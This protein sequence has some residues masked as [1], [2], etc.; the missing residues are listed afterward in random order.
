MA[1]VL[2][3]RTPVR[4][5]FPQ[6]GGLSNIWGRHVNAELGST[7][8]LGRCYST[9]TKAPCTSFTRVRVLLK[10]ER[11][12]KGDVDGVLLAVTNRYTDTIDAAV[13][14]VGNTL[15]GNPATG[16]I[17]ATFSGN[18]V[19]TLPDYNASEGKDA[20]LLWSD[21]MTIGSIAPTDGTTY[22]YIM[23]RIRINTNNYTYSNHG[24]PDDANRDTKQNWMRTAWKN[25][26]GITDPT[27]FANLSGGGSSTV[28]AIFGFEFE[29]TQ[30]GIRVLFCGDSITAGQ[31]A[32]SS[33]GYN[34]YSWAP[35]AIQTLR[36]EAL[37]LSCLNFGYP[38]ASTTACDLIAR[39]AIDFFAPQIACFS[40]YSSND[41]AFTQSIADAEYTRALAF[42]AYAWANGALPVLYFQTPSNTETGTQ[43]NLWTVLKD[44]VR[45]QSGFAMFDMRPSVSDGAFPERFVS[46]TNTDNLHPND[47]G[48][49]LM[50]TVCA[51]R[52]RAILRQNGL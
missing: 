9:I 49:D 16:W 29:S 17:Q 31:G 38:G 21:W 47:T 2:L 48:Y 40:V 11:A 33:N 22:P 30:T 10:N 32:A 51:N 28:T 26:D 20:G 27:N 4:Y 8:N 7:S 45:T 52:L 6:G 42:A 13:P 37:P 25:V 15:T 50:A 1:L 5:L 46:G 36:A 24:N 41:G 19:P 3:T 12:T 35:R 44:R 23:A 14:S 43:N 18:P 39:K 34:S